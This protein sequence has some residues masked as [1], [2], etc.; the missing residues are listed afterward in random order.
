MGG[1]RALLEICSGISKRQF[2]L[3][4]GSQLAGASD[5]TWDGNLESGT[6]FWTQ[7]R[8]SHLSKVDFK[9][10]TPPFVCGSF[11]PLS[12]PRIK[13]PFLF[14]SH[15]LLLLLLAGCYCSRSWNEVEPPLDEREELLGVIKEEATCTP[16]SSI[17]LTLASSGLTAYPVLSHPSK[18]TRAFSHLLFD[19]RHKTSTS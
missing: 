8:P 6:L 15:R 12:H 7:T 1:G 9:S 2:G 5:I 10:H 4:C 19:W 18:H 14:G 17:Y 3:K 13:S 11:F 16:A